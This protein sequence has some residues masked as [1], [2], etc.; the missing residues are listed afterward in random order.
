[1]VAQRLDRAGVRRVV[2]P[3]AGP[4]PGRLGPQPVRRLGHLPRGPVQPGGGHQ[5]VVA[6][7]EQL[8]QG[9]GALGQGGLAGRLGGVPQP[10]R[11]L[12]YVVQPGRAVGLGVLGGAV[13]AEHPSTLGLEDPRGDLGQ[14][15]LRQAGP[16]GRLEE[17]GEITVEVPGASSFQRRAYLVDRGG[18]LAVQ[19]LRRPVEAGQPLADDVQVADPADGDAEPPEVPAEP[20]GASESRRSRRAARCGSGGPGCGPGAR[21]RRRRAAGGSPRGRRAAR[22]GTP[23]APRR[24]RPCAHYVPSSTVPTCHRPGHA[25]A[26]PGRWSP[27]P[28]DCVGELG[29]A[30]WWCTCSSGAR[31]CCGMAGTAVMPPYV[32]AGR[33]L[34]LGGAAEQ[35]GQREPAGGGTHLGLV[36]LGDLG[37]E[38]GAD[39][40][41]LLGW[42]PVDDS[43]FR[44]RRPPADRA[45]ALSR[46]RSASDPARSA[47]QPPQTP[48][49]LV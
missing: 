7:A 40:G 39:H 27:Q 2:E 11:G 21:T 25:G 41:G 42:F 24:C 20:A 1:M 10:L 34:R 17:G 32:G 14:R 48:V 29:Q 19:Q 3:R 8:L 38:G 5:G 30:A 16:P 47:A 36:Q 13:A 35:A 49:Q 45:S 46:C 33:G 26:C 9:L 6:G 44:L 18:P 12:A 22:R 28:Q 31:R 4:L 43:R 37:A 15:R 23:E